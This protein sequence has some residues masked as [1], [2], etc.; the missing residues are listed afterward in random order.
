MGGNMPKKNRHRE[1]S[2]KLLKSTVVLDNSWYKVRKDRVQ[3]PSGVIIEDYFVSELKN[4][5][6]IFALTKN[7]EVVFVRQY[8]HPVKEVLLELPAGTYSAE[9]SARNVARRELLEETGY[10]ANK[11]IFLGKMLEYPT[12]DS[13][14]INLFLAKDVVLTKLKRPEATEDIETVLIPINKKQ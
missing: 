6:M 8:R 5:A 7:K 3:L 14:E 11:L 4:V 13:H 10:M 1:K 9:E 12:K 2:W